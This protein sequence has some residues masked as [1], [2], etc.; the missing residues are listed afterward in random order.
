M[1]C[2]DVTPNLQSRQRPDLSSR[3][4]SEPNDLSGAHHVPPRKK[5]CLPSPLNGFHPFL[6][7]YLPIYGSQSNVSKSEGAFKKKATLENIR[8]ML[9]PFP[10]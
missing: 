9:A 10:G 7:I 8:G 6:Q 3:E 4:L 1:H 2:I 5:T